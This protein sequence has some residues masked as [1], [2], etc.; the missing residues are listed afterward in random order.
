VPSN[1]KTQ[2]IP[3]LVAMRDILRHVQTRKELKKIMLEGKVEVNGVKILEQGYSLLLFDVL[4]LPTI[5]KQY[6]LVL[7]EFKK[8]AFEEVVAKDANSKIV[9]VIGKKILSKGVVQFNMR[10]GRNVLSKDKV[11]VGDS[12]IINF[13]DKKIEKVVPISE[14][15][16]VLVIKGKHLGHRGKVVKVSGN[17][18]NVSLGENEFNLNKNAVMA[19]S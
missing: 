10:D 14:K 12:V 1:N 16:E 8:F 17:E 13:K 4:S 11:G 5:K 6:R 9:K 15:S 3:V 7:T 19:L 2:G 18:V